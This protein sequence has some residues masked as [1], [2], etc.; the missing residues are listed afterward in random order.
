MNFV[1]VVYGDGEQYALKKSTH[2]EGV[3]ALYRLCQLHLKDIL[4]AEC[5]VSTD[6]AFN[7]TVEMHPD[8]EWIINEMRKRE[9]PEPKIALQYDAVKGVD[10]IG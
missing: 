8:R 9:F 5:E 4:G 2:W 10:Y 6:R 3:E 1:L 7:A